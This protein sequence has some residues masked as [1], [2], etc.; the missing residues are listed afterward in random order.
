MNKLVHMLLRQVIMA[1]MALVLV[2]LPFA[3][4]VGAAP[5]SPEMAQFLAMGGDPSDI[6]GGT[7]GHPS[8]GCENCTVGTSILLPPAVLGIRPTLVPRLLDG[9]LDD[10]QTA[11]LPPLRYTPPVRAPPLI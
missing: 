11:H 8:V 1:M 10:G 2:G 4:R 9:N 5:V 3:H 6:C 7:F